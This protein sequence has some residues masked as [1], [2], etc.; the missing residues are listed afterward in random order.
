MARNGK[1]PLLRFPLWKNCTPCQSKVEGQPMR[2]PHTAPHTVW[3]AV[4]SEP[5][6][7]A[8]QSRHSCWASL[9]WVSAARDVEKG[10]CESCSAESCQ[11]PPLPLGGRFF[12]SGSVWRK[13]R[14][15]RR[16]L[17]T[18]AFHPGRAQRPEKS[19]WAVVDPFSSAPTRSPPNLLAAAAALRKCRMSCSS[20]LGPPPPTPTSRRPQR[21]GRRAEGRGLS[22]SNWRRM[23]TTAGSQLGAWRLWQKGTPEQGSTRRAKGTG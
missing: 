18:Q 19:A 21:Q 7:E 4:P 10:H 2:G 17:P 23:E 8:G 6:S 14:L 15:T 12:S 9:R 22:T 3:A 13:P 5:G 11:L 16:G 20:Q 1:C